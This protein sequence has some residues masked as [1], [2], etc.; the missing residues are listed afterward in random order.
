M[1]NQPGEQFGRYELVSQLGRGGMAETWR[2]KLVG[3]AGVT[4]PVLIKKVLPEH[5]QDEAFTAMF[6]S[7]AR[8]TA[9]LSHGNIAQVFDFGEVDGEYFLAMEFVDGQPLN[10]VLKRAQK[11]GLP[12]LPVTVATCIA[13][14]MCKGLHYAHTRTD[15]AGE[16]LDIV[17]RDISPDNVLLSYEGQVKIVDFGIAKA[18]ALRNFKTEAGV[19]KG[20]YLFFSPEQARGMEV[21]ARSDVWSTAVV[22]YEMLCGRLPLEGPPHVVMRKLVNG[23]FPRPRELR[24]DVPA[25]LDEIVM[26][27]LTVER[28]ARTPSCHELGNEL[29]GFL[30]AAA[31]RFSSM[32]LSYLVK[33]LFRQDL[34]SQGREA[35]I[36]QSFVEEIAMWRDAA[37]ST[38]VR[39]VS[40]RERAL[41]ESVPSDDDD[42]PVSKEALAAE[43]AARLRHKLLAVLGGAA[44]LAIGV[45]VVATIPKEE[46]PA[47]VPAQALARPLPPAPARPQAAAPVE[48][49]AVKEPV[50]PAVAEA[51]ARPPA[52]PPVETKAPKR[53]S[54]KYPVD[55][56]LLEAARDMVRPSDT[57]ASTELDPRATYRLYEESPSRDNPPL[58]Y[59]LT[60]EDSLSA[61]ASVGMVSTKP[62]TVKGVKKVTIFTVGEPPARPQVRYVQLEDVKSSRRNPITI[63]PIRVNPVMSVASL[64]RAF[65]LEGLDG[66]SVYELKLVSD[67]EGALLRGDSGGEVRKV[68]CARQT[69]ESAMPQAQLE[70]LNREQQFLLQPGRSVLVKAARAVS[71]GF[72]D[73]DPSDNEGALEVR[74]SEV[75]RR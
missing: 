9:T 67:Q 24:P 70:R 63:D 59:L 69:D 52:P 14:E 71:C 19:V 73:K 2:A 72:V 60:G 48:P 22:L 43:E 47:P 11:T 8:I 15:E 56:I 44:A 33:E 16:P 6:I 53:G 26:R 20:K 23:D 74:I 61:E 49:P 58:F 12:A 45:G 30:Y 39:G 13:M 55:S 57:A 36:P 35:R 27:A 54:A 3:A 31:P 40:S 17:H 10:R 4:K 1:E 18:R 28:D 46:P 42:V 29:A 37:K 25:E 50:A 64:E 62:V 38:K 21:D 41:R 75:R 65:T 34:T 5:S 7:E 68:V 66:A 51:P 32:S